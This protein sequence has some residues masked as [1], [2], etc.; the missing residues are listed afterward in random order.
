MEGGLRTIFWIRDCL[1]HL[2]H[3]SKLQKTTTIAR[4]VGNSITYHLFSKFAKIHQHCVGYL[5]CALMLGFSPVI[6]FFY[7]QAPLSS[8]RGKAET[9]GL[10]ISTMLKKIHGTHLSVPLSHNRCLHARP[11]APFLHTMTPRTH[12]ENSLV[13]SSCSPAAEA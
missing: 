7:M 10:S 9:A 13:F 11:L 2:F 4:E 5:Q 1:L 12:F 6:N 3:F 8:W